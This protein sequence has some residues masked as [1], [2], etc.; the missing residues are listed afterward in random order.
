MALFVVLWYYRKWP[1]LAEIANDDR[2]FAFL[3]NNAIR[4][5]CVHHITKP[6]AYDAVRY[7]V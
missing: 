6:L 4:G 1:H 7:S 5:R 3:S 2:M